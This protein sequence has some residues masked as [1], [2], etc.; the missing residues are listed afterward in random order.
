MDYKDYL[1]SMQF[2]TWLGPMGSFGEPGPVGVGYDGSGTT[3]EFGQAML[4][5]SRPSSS[6]ISVVQT[7][8]SVA[9]L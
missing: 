3:A 6:S 2:G 5:N 8:V 4:W 7:L 1:S 9:S